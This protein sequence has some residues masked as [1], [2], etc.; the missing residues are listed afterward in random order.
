MIGINN[1]TVSFGGETLLD[2]VNFHV[3]PTDKVALV[4]RNGA[5]KTTLLRLVCGIQNPT[6]GRIDISPSVRLGYLPQIMKISGG[7]TIMEEALSAFSETN[8][9]KDELDSLNE[10]LSRRTDY[11][12]ASYMSLVQ[13]VSQVSELLALGGT[14]PPEVQAAKTLLG[15]GFEEKDFSRPRSEMSQGWN[16]R[17]ELAKILLSHP[18]C[19]LLD[20]PTNHLDLESIEWLEGYLKAFRGAIILVSHDRRFLDNVTTRTIEIV[21]GKIQDYKV[22]YSQYLVLREERLSQQKAAYANQQRMIEKTEDFIAKFRYKPTKSNQ[23]QSRIKAL[24]KLERIEVDQTDNTSLMVKFPPAPR[25]GDVV[26]KG[27]GLSVGYDGIPVFTG[28]NVE[29]RRGEKVALVGR[30]GQGKT[31]LMKVIVGDLDPLEGSATLGHNVSIGY[32]AQNQ[33]D[34]LDRSLTV[35]ETVD[36]AAVGEVRTKLRDI[37]AQFLFRGEDIDKRVSV[38]SGGERARLG[39]AKLML[40]PYNLLC[41][42]EPTNHMDIKSKE[43]LREALSAYDGTLVVVSHDREFLSG[44]VDKL[45]EV[46]DGVVKEHLGGVD[47]F[48]A[49]KKMESLRELERRYGGSAPAQGEKASQVAAKAQ[50][51]ASSEPSAPAKAQKS[52]EEARADYQRR[53]ESSKEWKK[54]KSRLDFL[55][56]EIAKDEKGMKDLEKIL[57]NPGPGDDI[58]ELTRDYLNFKRDLDAREEEWGRLY[59]EMEGGQ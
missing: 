13:R 11:E 58:M 42:D 23:V 51:G 18:D 7:G 28:A 25:S 19:L 49:R 37:L 9:L 54:K 35:F 31:T 21:L 41:L 16:M 38:L 24:E 3:S 52:K 10:E 43:I 48:L 27:E 53:K 40:H 29:V 32:Y 50:N 56:K 20:E 4:G 14:E 1:I 17:L 57:S 45:Y 22:P 5:G 46:S 30:N 39:M 2:C 59:E 8:A 15:L 36:R 55:E 47:D 12:S 44:L 26:F 33:E 6:S 34:V